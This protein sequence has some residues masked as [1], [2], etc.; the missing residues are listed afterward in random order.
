M[1]EWCTGSSYVRPAGA[2]PC[3]LGIC[4]PTPGVQ[5]LPEL[6]VDLGLQAG[7]EEQLMGRSSRPLSMCLLGGNAL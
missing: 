2:W 6:Q 4:L 1:D 7:P 5:A 3:V